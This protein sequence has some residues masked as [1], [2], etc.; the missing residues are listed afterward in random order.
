MRTSIASGLL[1]LAVATVAPSPSLAQSNGWNGF[2]VGAHLGRSWGETG[3]SW[4]FRPAGT[5]W[6]ADGEISYDS[7]SGGIHAGHLWQYGPLAFGV[8][9][10]FT[11]GSL[12]GDDSKFAG[13]LNALEMDYVSTIRGRLGFVNGPSLIYATAGVALAE[14]D[15]KD[16]DAQ[17]SV[18]NDVSGWTVG[19]GYEH[20]L[21]GGLRARVEYQYV[22]FGSTVSGLA[23]D[24]RAD[25][26][27]I[28][29]VRGGM[30]YGF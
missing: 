13:A 14:L 30:S 4:R 1:I 19:A 22:N 25:D 24:H 28:H 26:L 10:D 29:T 2:Y 15:K 5:S 9:G 3:N 17:T 27:D 8:E 12:K 7:T 6:T 21:W 23:Y 11:W 18:S 16:L 20:M